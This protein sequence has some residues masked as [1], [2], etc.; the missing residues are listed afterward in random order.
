[1]LREW[2]IEISSFYLHKVPALQFYRNKTKFFKTSS[3]LYMSEFNLEDI[4]SKLA[5]QSV[6]CRSNKL[7]VIK[8]LTS[9]VS[10]Y[11]RVISPTFAAIAVLNACLKVMMYF[12]AF[13]S[14]VFPYMLKG[15]RVGSW[16]AGKR[17]SQISINAWRLLKQ[18]INYLICC[19]RQRFLDRSSLVKMACLCSQGN[20]LHVT[21]ADNTGILPD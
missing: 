2:Y 21:A 15:S 3:F 7:Y 9:F 6:L 11:L 20:R 4:A 13:A 16:F 12:S 14:E 1:M 19:L 10:L 5:E 17:G 18:K 8:V